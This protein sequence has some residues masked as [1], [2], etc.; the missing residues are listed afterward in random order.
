MFCFEYAYCFKGKYYYGASELVVDIVMDELD[1]F[2]KEHGR[3]MTKTE[4][5]DTFPNIRI[6]TRRAYEPSD[7]AKNNKNYIVIE[8]EDGIYSLLRYSWDNR[9]LHDFIGKIK[10]DFEEYKNK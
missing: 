5:T 3:K 9:N 10:C 8:L 7:L 4:F 1:K 2:E 6:V